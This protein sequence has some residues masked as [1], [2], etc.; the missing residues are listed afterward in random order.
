MSLCLKGII[1]FSLFITA[2]PMNYSIPLHYFVEFILYDKG[3][4]PLATSIN[5][6]NSIMILA[7]C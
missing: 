7:W 3:Q 6:L 1:I 5:N 4:E 2:L